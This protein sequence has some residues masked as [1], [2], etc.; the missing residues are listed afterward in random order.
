MLGLALLTGLA[1]ALA[2]GAMNGLITTR[3]GIS[4]FIAT[5]GTMFFMRGAVRFVSL[6]PK[7]NQPDNI[8]FFPGDTLKALLGGQAQAVAIARAVHFKRDI[9][10]LDEPTRLRD[11]GRGGAR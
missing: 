10:L 8:A 6:N 9:L 7:T 11:A 5:L 4:S 2:I 3:L 1:T